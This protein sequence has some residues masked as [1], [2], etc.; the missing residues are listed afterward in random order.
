MAWSLKYAHDENG[1]P[2]DGSLGDLMD[3][4]GRGAAVRVAYVVPPE[5]GS[6]YRQLILDLHT[7]ILM[8]AHVHGHASYPS[9]KP[10]ADNLRFETEH[11]P[12]LLNLSTSGKVWRREVTGG[13]GTVLRTND[14]K[15]ALRWYCDA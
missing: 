1:N 3:A 13:D 11:I 14:F 12:Y 9:L 15:W 8:S 5:E 10:E 4:V 2:E 7:V 6:P